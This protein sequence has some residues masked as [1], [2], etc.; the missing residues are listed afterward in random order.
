MNTRN[1]TIIIVGIIA[2]TL[3]LVSFNYL[4]QGVPDNPL[5]PTDQLTSTTSPATDSPVQDFT[6]VLYKV[7]V[8]ETYV[9]VTDI[10]L[11]QYPTL[12]AALH[13]LKDSENDHIYYRTV[14]HSATSAWNYIYSKY[15]NETACA[16]ITFFNYGDYFYSFRLII[17]VSDPSFSESG[18]LSGATLVVEKQAGISP[19]SYVTLTEEDLIQFPTLQEALQILSGNNMT[20][21]WYEIREREGDKF[22]TYMDNRYQDQFECGKYC[23]YRIFEYHGEFYR[24]AMMIA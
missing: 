1:G 11:E 23:N 19:T 20:E 14:D 9:I 8:P 2:I 5:P 12:Q 13:N 18:S 15:C 3:L 4:D 6:L 16:S 22:H 24:F 10:E 21:V 7:L 17:R